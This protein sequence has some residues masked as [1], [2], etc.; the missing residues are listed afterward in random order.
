MKT[1]LLLAAVFYS[2]E[3]YSQSYFISFKGSGAS[4]SVSTVRV[5]NLTREASVEFSGKAILCLTYATSAGSTAATQPNLKIYPN[6]VTE[7]AMLEFIAP[8]PGDAGLKIINLA[9]I[10]LAG[11]GMFL[12][13]ARHA[14]LITGLPQGIYIVSIE[15]KGYRYSGRLVSNNTKG[16]SP[17]I[18]KILE[19]SGNLYPGPELRESRNVFADTIVMEYKTGD[20]LKFTAK[21]GEFSTVVIDIP[22]SDKVMDFEFIPCTDIDGNNYK[23]VKIKDNYWMAENLRTTRYTNGVPIMH[24][25]DDIIWERS[26]DYEERDFYCYYDDDTVKRNKFGNLYNFRAAGSEQ[27]RGICPAD[28]HIVNSI[29]LLDAIKLYEPE[30]YV[31]EEVLRA[32]GAF[33]ESGTASWNPPNTGATNESGFSALPGGIRDIA[34][35]GLGNF[36]SWWLGYGHG[37]RLDNSSRRLDYWW[38]RYSGGH[39][40]RCARDLVATGPAGSVQLTTAVSGGNVYNEGGSS[41]IRKGVCWGTEE[42]TLKGAHTNDGNGPGPFTSHLTGLLPGTRYYL[43]AYAINQKDTLYGKQI[44]FNT[45][46]A[47]VDGNLY[48]TVTIG[49]QT[50]LAENLRTT[51]FNDGT[52]LLYVPDNSAWESLYMSSTRPAYCWLDNDPKNKE[53]YGAIYDFRALGDYRLIEEEHNKNLCPAGWHVPGGNEWFELVSFFDPKAYYKKGSNDAFQGPVSDTAGI[54]L[55]EAGYEHWK[56]ENN[57]ATNE[58]GFTNLP[59][60]ARMQ[61]GVFVNDRGYYSTFKASETWS[62][63]TKQVG[64]V[65]GHPGRGY[66]VRCIKDN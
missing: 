18:Q 24:V 8:F 55:S 54:F 30:A 1:L 63:W 37:F 12:E 62:I 36:G 45:R 9:G 29:E 2:M 7:S 43:R 57:P 13:N 15:G 47:D 51:K 49:R 60:G 3:V 21:S 66:S 58:T 17:A 26:G 27:T 61:N 65:H 33:K 44:I 4:T 48:K 35:T 39:S 25:T 34:F 11:T 52:P 5:E 6:P 46:V 28:W 14:F 59:A 22:G 42:A 32:G 20:R 31:L 53:V 19:G 56:V 10:T 50:W 16:G 41:V 38:D 64:F 23:V 40:I